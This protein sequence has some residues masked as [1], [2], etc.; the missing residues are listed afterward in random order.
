MSATIARSVYGGPHDETALLSLRFER[1]ATAQMCSS[2]LWDAPKSLEV[3]GTRGHAFLVDTLGPHGGGR[4]FTHVGELEF[5]QTSPYVGQ[6][7][8]FVAAV[9]ENRPPEVDGEEGLRNIELMAHAV[10]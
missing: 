7:E 5:E 9:R 2:V 3:F 4:I 1:G 8:D 6:V 10:A